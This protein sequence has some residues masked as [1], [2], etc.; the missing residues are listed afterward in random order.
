MYNRVIF[1][2][3]KILPDFQIFQHSNFTRRQ[4]GGFTR[5]QCGGFT[6]R[7]CGGLTRPLSGGLDSLA[8]AR[9]LC[10]GPESFFFNNFF[11]FGK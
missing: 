5:R 10:G 11:I 9:C 3:Q 1:I 2:R 7:Q 8:F 6:R 4:C